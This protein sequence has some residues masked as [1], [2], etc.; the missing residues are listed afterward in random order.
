[1]E[2]FSV[3]QIEEIRYLRLDPGEPLLES[4]EQY[5]SDMNIR[6]AIVFSSAGSLSHCCFHIVSGDGTHPS[7]NEFIE[8]SGSIEIISLS[9][10]IVDYEPHLHICIGKDRVLNGGHLEHGC[11]VYT[12]AEISIAIIKP[13]ELTR[14]RTPEITGYHYKNIRKVK[15]EG[16][17]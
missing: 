9:G 7:D 3:G 1:M 13:T 12:M 17:L 15:K 5:I 10:I 14:L 16:E 8:L 2:A 11:I 6:D 4:L